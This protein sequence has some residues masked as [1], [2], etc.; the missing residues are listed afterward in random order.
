MIYSFQNDHC[1]CGAQIFCQ[2][3]KLSE[4]YFF[5]G[6]GPISI[7]DIK[8]PRVALGGVTFE[9][10]GERHIANNWTPERKHW[11][12]NWPTGRCATLVGRLAPP[13]G[14][15]GVRALLSDPFPAPG[16][17]KNPSLMEGRASGA[18]TYLAGPPPLP[19]GGVVLALIKALGGGPVPVA[20]A[21]RAS[22]RAAWV[23]WE[24]GDQIVLWTAN[25][26]CFE[27]ELKVCLGLRKEFFETWQF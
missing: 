12:I 1:A 20:R 23:R 21:R 8:P 22:R 7:A 6:M 2:Q 26:S 27:C 16:S 15:S 3:Q 10:G 9:A 18:A 17:Q 13:D 25:S 24:T 4:K 14:G 19:G 5:S 11:H